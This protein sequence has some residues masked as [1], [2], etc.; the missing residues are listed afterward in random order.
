MT[1]Y[2]CTNKEKIIEMG[3]HVID[4]SATC[5]ICGNPISFDEIA[6]KYREDKQIRGH[7]FHVFHTKIKIV[8]M[9]CGIGGYG[10]KIYCGD[11]E[12]GVKKLFVKESVEVENEK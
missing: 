12:N 3:W 6:V 8:C 9:S 7:L 5:D 10:L 4:Y 2:I 1:C 11:W